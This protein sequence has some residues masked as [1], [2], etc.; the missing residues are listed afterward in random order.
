MSY[1]VG[2]D[3]GGTF[4]DI[5]ILNENTG[6]IIV[7]KTPTIPKDQSLS[8]FNVLNSIKEKDFFKNI[9]YIIHG[10]T[11]A[12]NALLERK[13][14]KT[15]FITTKGF[16][17]L[18]YI[19]RQTRPHMYDFWAKK[20]E[21]VVPRYLT[22]EI[23]E[24]T[25][26]TGEIERELDENE[27]KMTIEKIKEHKIESIA[28]C[29][30]HSYANPHNELKLYEIAKKELPNVHISLSSEILPE[31]REYERAS[32]VSINAYLAPT[33]EKYL[34]KLEL[35]KA[36][37]GIKPEIHIMQSN[38]GIISAKQAWEQSVRTI[39]SGPAGGALLGT[40]ISKQLGIDKIITLDMGGT[41]TDLCL[42]IKTPRIVNE[43]EIDGFP[44]R[45][46]MIDIHT[47]GA[48]GGSIAWIDKGGILQ[49]GPH[50]AGSYPG[51]VCYQRGGKEPTSTD[52]NLVLGRINP[53]YFLGGEMKINKNLAIMSIKE[54]ISSYFKID[55]LTA[56]NAILDIIN[57]NMIR[58]IKVISVEKGL[59]PGEFALVAFGGAGPLHA[60]SLARELKIKKIIIPPNP[61]N[62]SALG[63]LLA[64]IR[65]D[66]VNTYIK[67]QKNLT[68][69]EINQIFNKLKNKAIETLKKEG[70]NEQEI[71]IFKSIDMRYTGQSFELN[72]P[73]NID[74]V[75]RE[76]FDFIAN[77]FEEIH[78]NTYGYRMENEEII[79]VNFRLN[80]IGKMPE[81]KIKPLKL[82]DSNPIHA[83]K[84][85][86]EV[87]FENQTILCNIY[88]REKL[89]AGNE[90]EGPAVIEEYASTTIIPEFSIA[91]IDKFK[92]IILKIQE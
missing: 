15:A 39:F 12:T 54:R 66:Y 48:G 18:L 20:P 30:L 6:E 35:R 31:Y 92:N 28:V 7:N 43:A 21:P 17:D 24:R 88:Q 68:P 49:V 2:I 67:N 63:F 72:V 81:F 74:I 87:F 38:G 65:V 69:N 14:A 44:I 3:V 86:R 64:D 62:A 26:Y 47:I 91:K 45:I 82:E 36:Q 40:Y 71:L 8:V 25:L 41:S 75:N 77:Q 55:V 58:G 37:L 73:I 78:E 16:K 84:G 85:K 51:P 27:V 46:P 9:V 60:A 1:R 56:S 79:F 42:I 19:Q 10:T 23:N 50:S 80:A 61:A 70:F 34:K 13:G 90:I 76:D 32:T 53:D 59:D 4:T 89:K 29:F 57:S 33:I 5:T 52:A 22:F 11:V 83:L